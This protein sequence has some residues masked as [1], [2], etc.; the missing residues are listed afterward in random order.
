M[1]TLLDNAIESRE[2]IRDFETVLSLLWIDA[3]NLSDEEKADAALTA[4]QKT[5]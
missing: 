2:K 3:S 4:L 5:C 1:D